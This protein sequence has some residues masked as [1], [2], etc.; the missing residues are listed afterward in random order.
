MAARNHY[1]RRLATT[2][3]NSLEF[4][5]LIVLHINR[6]SGNVRGATTY[7]YYKGL[8]VSPSLC[9]AHDQTGTTFSGPQSSPSTHL[10]YQSLEPFV[11]TRLHTFLLSTLLLRTNCKSDL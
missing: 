9:L 1:R 3:I 5:K 10:D 7:Y 2:Y 8:P 6:A 4:P 11:L